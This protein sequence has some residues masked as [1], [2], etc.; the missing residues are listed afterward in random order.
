[1]IERA[2][3]PQPIPT[4]ENVS[5]HTPPL[6]YRALTPLYD[7]AI[8]LL[9]QEKVWRSRLV[10]A[11]DPRPEDRV[12]D[13]GSGTGSLAILVHKASPNTLFKGVDPDSDAVRR[14]R[15]KAERH[16]SNAKF[17]IGYLSADMHV[18]GAAPNKITSSLVLHQTPMTEKTRILE[19]MFQI[20]APG[21]ELHIADYGLQK[22]KLMRALFRWTVQ[23]IDG[24]DNTQ[25][26][27]DGV[28]HELIRSAGFVEV[29]AYD[30]IPTPTGMISLFRAAKPR[31]Q[32]EGVAI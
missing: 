11:I 14:A 17:R 13:V 9:T 2:N 10:V 15:A 7:A 20:L 29:E 21:G 8:A 3:R 28:I 16:G 22:S 24:V 27:A 31:A 30:Q 19:T 18:G 1:M 5:S 12:L 6:G 32:S 4:Q 23:S 25:P 26:N